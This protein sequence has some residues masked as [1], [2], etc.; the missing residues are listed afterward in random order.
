[1]KEPL[2]CRIDAG[3]LTKP[4]SGVED[5]LHSDLRK[6]QPPPYEVNGITKQRSC[7]VTYGASELR[8][9]LT[10]RGSEVDRLCARECV[11]SL[12]VKAR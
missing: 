6:R 11:G 10:G 1:M 8:A 4:K 5:E 7:F 9:E 12:T 3:G 2:E